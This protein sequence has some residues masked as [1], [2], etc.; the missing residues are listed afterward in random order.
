MAWTS[1]LCSSPLQ[2]SAWAFQGLFIVSLLAPAV[3]L[4]L[5]GK[6]RTRSFSI[7][8]CTLPSWVEVWMC[9]LAVLPFLESIS[10]SESRLFVLAGGLWADWSFQV[11]E[12]WWASA[13]LVWNDVFLQTLCWTSERITMSSSA[14]LL[15]QILLSHRRWLEPWTEW[16]N[17]AECIVSMAPLLSSSPNPNWIDAWRLLMP[18]NLCTSCSLPL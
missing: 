1:T 6:N 10:S 18:Q 15:Y 9:I 16:S 13:L 8:V 5:E 12:L 4:L 7:L 11:F 17:E 3:D 2:L 14:C